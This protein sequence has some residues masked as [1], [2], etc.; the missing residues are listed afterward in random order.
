M[1]LFQ[2]NNLD[3][4]ISEELKKNRE[5]AWR[6]EITEEEQDTRHKE[7]MQRFRME[8]ERILSLRKNPY[9]SLP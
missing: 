4:E 6:R 7:I 9:D 1:I 8:T 2:L 3:N 5:K